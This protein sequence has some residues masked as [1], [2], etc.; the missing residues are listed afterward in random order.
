[1]RI[2][3]EN[4]RNTMSKTKRE[5]KFACKKKEKSVVKRLMKS[6]KNMK[7]DFFLNNQNLM[8]CLNEWRRILKDCI[9]K[10]VRFK[11]SSQIKNE[12]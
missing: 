9:K 4:S 11:Q 7:N 2:S 8:I 12:F 5:W 6:R 10:K 1:M 3:F